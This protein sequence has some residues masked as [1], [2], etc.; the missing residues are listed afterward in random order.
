MVS[1]NGGNGALSDLGAPGAGSGGALI[2]FVPAVVNAGI[3]RAN[4]GSGGGG[5]CCGGGG[6]GGGGRLLVVSSY[7]GAGSTSANGGAGG[8]GNGAGAAGAVGQ[9]Q[10]FAYGAGPGVFLADPSDLAI[11]KRII[12]PISPEVGI[13]GQ[14]LIYQVDVHN[15]G[16]DVA[17]DVVVTDMLPANVILMGATAACVDNAGT[18]TCSLGTLDVGASQSFQV[19]IFLPADLV[20][21]QPDGTLEITNQASVSSLIPDS[22]SPNNQA[23]ITSQVQDLADLRITQ[24]IE[25]EQIVQAGRNITYTVFV[26]NLGPSYARD[27]R[28]NDSLLSGGKYQVVTVRDDP[29]RTDS[30]VITPGFGTQTSSSTIDCTL[31]DA[32]PGGGTANDAL[33]PV[34]NTVNPA[35]SPNTGRWSVTIV[36]RASTSRGY[37]QCSSGV[38]PKHNTCQPLPR[39]TRP[40]PLQ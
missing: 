23:S 3:V 1:A 17:V 30:C 12:S 15:F 13:A 38:Y 21:S 29:N 28:F 20:A 27:V 39:H 24:V 19:K 8:S 6:G 7:S 5:G 40:R 9:V 32:N 36:L 10:T 16:P 2:L 14:E 34:G 33:E 18:L 4:G 25:P 35:P 37:H 11:T 22:F 26:D 31:I